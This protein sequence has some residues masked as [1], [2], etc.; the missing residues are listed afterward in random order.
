MAYRRLVREPVVRDQQLFGIVED[1]YITHNWPLIAAFNDFTTYV[2]IT[3]KAKH[4]ANRAQWEDR[5]FASRASRV[6]FKVDFF[7]EN[8]TGSIKKIRSSE[9]CL[10]PMN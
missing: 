5:S 9:S 7:T 1:V 4:V 8:I 2:N 3:A 6:I 10:A